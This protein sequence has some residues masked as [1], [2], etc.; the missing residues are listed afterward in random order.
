MHAYSMPTNEFRTT[1]ERV[2]RSLPLSTVC[3]RS[4]FNILTKCRTE[5]NY[6]VSRNVSAQRTQNAQLW[7]C[8]VY[9]LLV[10]ATGCK[11]SE[12]LAQCRLHG[13]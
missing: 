3:D 1:T 5:T 6:T 11:E 7:S 2:C 4:H 10:V 8:T 9:E 12:P 13:R